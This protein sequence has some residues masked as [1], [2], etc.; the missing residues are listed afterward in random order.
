MRTDLAC[1]AR[2]AQEL[3]HEVADRHECFNCG[4]RIVIGDN[5][6]V[7]DYLAWTT[8]GSKGADHKHGQKRRVG[9][10]PLRLE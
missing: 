9:L 1:P 2:K 8:A 10:K 7:S 4:Y 6:N 3:R 5:G